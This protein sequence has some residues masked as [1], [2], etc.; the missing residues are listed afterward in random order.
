MMKAEIR[1]EIL[2]WKGVGDKRTEKNPYSDEWLLFN[3]KDEDAKDAISLARN[4]QHANDRG[5]LCT[6][7][8]VFADDEKVGELKI[9]R[10]FH[11]EARDASGK[12][13][14]PS[15]LRIN[16]VQY[17]GGIPGYHYARLAAAEFS[18]W[19][20]LSNSIPDSDAREN[21]TPDAPLF[22]LD[23]GPIR[24]VAHEVDSPERARHLEWQAE[25]ERRIKARPTVIYVPESGT[26]SPELSA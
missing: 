9:R 17:D 1:K 26:N 16:S 3:F 22:R 23:D 8:D 7:Y 21:F 5:L 14:E 12:R 4:P 15:P 13:L 19:L 18:E 6:Y 25:Q 10:Y 24:F 2:S 20:Y 11:G